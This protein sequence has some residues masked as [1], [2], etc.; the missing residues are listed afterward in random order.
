M[1]NSGTETARMHGRDWFKK[2][3]HG[4]YQNQ[5][6][7]QI[8]RVSETIGDLYI[9]IREESSVKFDFW[10]GQL[11]EIYIEKTFVAAGCRNR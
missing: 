8:D 2:L 3:T 4:D 7:F 10:M 11:R 6:I 1:I 5:N 9:Y